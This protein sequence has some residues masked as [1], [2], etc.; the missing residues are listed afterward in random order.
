MQ[1]S[2]LQLYKKRDSGTEHLFYRTPPSDCPCNCSGVPFRQLLRR[3]LMVSSVEISLNKLLSPLQT[4]CTATYEISHFS[5]QQVITIEWHPKL[6]SLIGVF[7]CV[8]CY[9]KPLD[10]FLSMIFLQGSAHS[11]VS[12]LCLEIFIWWKKYQLHSLYFT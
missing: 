3:S 1:A 4:S 12:G 9:K 10:D 5:I 6:M 11:L 7:F 2:G 8:H